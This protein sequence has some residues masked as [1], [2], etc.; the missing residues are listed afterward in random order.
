MEEEEEE[1]EER[2]GREIR[3]G[4]RL[5]ESPGRKIQFRLINP[6]INRHKQMGKKNYER[7][8]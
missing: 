1:E 8:L 3:D 2:G 5:K 6:I 4:K 7:N